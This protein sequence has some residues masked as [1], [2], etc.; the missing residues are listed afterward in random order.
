M[1]RGVP[2][3]CQ[4]LEGREHFRT[5]VPEVRANKG[6]DIQEEAKIGRRHVKLPE[7]GGGNGSIF[8]VREKIYKKPSAQYIRN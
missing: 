1:E 7:V 6:L 8:Q 4:D 5:Q 3:W 2:K